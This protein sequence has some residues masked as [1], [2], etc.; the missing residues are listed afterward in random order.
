MTPTVGVIWNFSKW[1]SEGRGSPVWKG[2]RASGKAWRRENY[3]GA[4]STGVVP[5]RMKHKELVGSYTGLA[6]V[7]EACGAQWWRPFVSLANFGF[8]PI[9]KGESSVV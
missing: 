9:V 6:V 2:V 1:R 5:I 8:Q 3:M 7:R 4:W